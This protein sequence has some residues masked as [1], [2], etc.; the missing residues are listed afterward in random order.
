MVAVVLADGGSLD[1]E[2]LAVGLVPRVVGLVLFAG[3][4]V[5][6]CRRV[7]AL[8]AKVV[9]MVQTDSGEWARVV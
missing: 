8:M 4:D 6:F 2:P 7:G 1:L 9:R 3:T 5:A